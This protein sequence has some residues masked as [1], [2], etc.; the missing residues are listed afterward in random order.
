MDHVMRVSHGKEGL[1]P[2]V[3]CGAT[4][5]R[6]KSHKTKFKKCSF[7]I[8][9]QE[10][11]SQKVKSAWRKERERERGIEREREEDH[12]EEFLVKRGSSPQISPRVLCTKSSKKGVKQVKFA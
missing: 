1:Y 8:W 11:Q 9:N 4:C 10:V 7:K 12:Q 3:S 6:A 5:Q 2:S